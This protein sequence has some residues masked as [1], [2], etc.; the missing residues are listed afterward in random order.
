M[1]E[2]ISKLSE[3]ISQQAAMA[4]INLKLPSFSGAPDQEI[5]SFLRDFKAATLTLNDE[6]RCLA[7]HRS[8][9]GPARVWAK[10]TIKDDLDVGDWESAKTKLRQRFLPPGED[11]RL[12]SKLSKMKYDSSEM[13][14]SSYVEVYANLF[15][16]VHKRAPDSDI[17]GHLRLNLPPE[18]L[19]HLNVLSSTWTNLTSFKDFIALVTRVERDI[20]PYEVKPKHDDNQNVAALTAAIKELK[21]TV[22]AQKNALAEASKPVEVV[23]AIASNSNSQ[24]RNQGQNRYNNQSR[25]KRNYQDNGQQ[26]NSGGYRKR[27]SPPR[28]DANQ[29]QESESSKELFR[30]YEEEHGPVP[31]PCK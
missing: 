16:K 15:G 6:L 10:S 1:D 9:T 21:E 29:T 27:F 12:L 28:S 30:K 5:N 22:T 14:L 24:Q 20:L 11:L 4:L 13:T 26:G 7:L 19:K 31:G 8:L 18:I 25:N 3:S 2:T 17:I 23:A